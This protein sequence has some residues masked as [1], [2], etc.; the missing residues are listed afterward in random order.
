MRFRIESIRENKK[1]ATAIEVQMDHRIVVA[2][3]SVVA[4]LAMTGI[5]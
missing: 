5:A 3:A 4:G 2:I 1:I